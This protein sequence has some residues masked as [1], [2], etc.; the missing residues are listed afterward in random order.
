MW[1]AVSVNVRQYITIDSMFILLPTEKI[2]FTYIHVKFLGRCNIIKSKNGHYYKA[3]NE[4]YR[5]MQ[6]S[7]LQMFNLSIPV[8][9]FCCLV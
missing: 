4:A 6:Y 9:D 8:R 2:T 1:T 5:K 3:I 7:V